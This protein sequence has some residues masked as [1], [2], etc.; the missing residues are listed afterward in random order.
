MLVRCALSWEYAMPFGT[1]WVRITGGANML[2]R[3]RHPM[4][5]TGRQW[6][7]ATTEFSVGCRLCSINSV[8]GV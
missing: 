5:G 4:A 3:G 6:R 7:K 1:I 2:L 8:T